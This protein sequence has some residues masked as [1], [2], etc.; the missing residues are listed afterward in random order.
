[1]SSKV[2]D[3]D[4]GFKNYLKSLDKL[5][6]PTISVGVFADDKGMAAHEERGKEQVKETVLDVAIKNE[7]GLGVPE[8]SFIRAWFDMAQGQIKEIVNKR[9][10]MVVLGKIGRGQAIEQIGPDTTENKERDRPA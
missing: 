5:K 10:R 8:R 7:F 6:H 9:L 3:T 1:M 2:K 4:K